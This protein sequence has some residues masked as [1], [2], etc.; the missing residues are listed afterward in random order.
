MLSIRVYG[1]ELVRQ[2]G[3]RER[4]REKK[5]RKHVGDRC[6]LIRIVELG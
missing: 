3:E 1:K 5:E 4:E 6:Y 2:E